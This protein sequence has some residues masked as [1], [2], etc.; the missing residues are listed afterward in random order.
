MSAHSGIGNTVQIVVVDA[1]AAA[2]VAVGCGVTATPGF[3][4]AVVVVGVLWRQ[5][6]EAHLRGQVGHGG[7]THALRE[8]RQTNV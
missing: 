8:Q 6:I 7:S 3:L 4:L 5:E 1:A 2:P